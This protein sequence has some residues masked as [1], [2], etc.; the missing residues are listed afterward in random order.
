MEVSLSRCDQLNPQ[1]LPPYREYKRKA[2]SCKIVGK[3]SSLW[4]PFPHINASEE[5]QALSHGSRQPKH[6]DDSDAST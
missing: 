4:Q 2:D 5:Y 6:P 1:S 3:V